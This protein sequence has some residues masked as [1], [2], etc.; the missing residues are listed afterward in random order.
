MHIEHQKELPWS[1]R[2]TAPMWA[3]NPSKYCRYHQNHGHDMEEYWQLREEIEALIRWGCLRCYIDEWQILKNPC[4]ELSRQKDLYR[5]Q[6]IAKEIRTISG[7]QLSHDTSKPRWAKEKEPKKRKISDESTFSKA[8]LK[9]IE[10]PHDDPI[11]V[12]L[13][14]SNYDIHQVLIDNGSLV[15]ILF[16]SIFIWMNLNSERLVKRNSSLIG[17]LSSTI[18]IEGTISLTTI[19]GRAPK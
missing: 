5:K 9:G 7:W 17:F 2:M 6:P 3:K 1:R 14:I 15:N 11:M 16:Y 18:P 12:S 19:A 4:G 13:N 10:C 8:D